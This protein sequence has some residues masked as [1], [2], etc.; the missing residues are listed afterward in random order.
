MHGSFSPDPD[1]LRTE[2]AEPD[3]LDVLLIGLNS[4][5][6][7]D[8]ASQLSTKCRSLL[9]ADLDDA[10]QVL[11]T[12][13]VRV[14]CLGDQTSPI[15]T[16]AFLIKLIG[17][18]TE[19][20]L[21][22]AKPI[23]HH[24]EIAALSS[25]AADSSAE[26][27]DAD[28][29]VSY[30]YER[31]RGNLTREAK[32]TSRVQDG[33]AAGVVSYVA[34][35]G[36]SVKCTDVGVNPRYESELDNDSEPEDERILAVPVPAPGEFGTLSTRTLAVLVVIRHAAANV[37]FDADQ[38]HLD[39]FAEHLRADFALATKE[40]CATSSGPMYRDQRNGD[41]SIFRAEAIKHH[42]Q[43]T[44]GD[45]HPLE[46][47]PRWA[48]L[49]FPLILLA[50][51]AGLVY[52]Q[53]GDVDEYT[54]SITID[55]VNPGVAV[56]DT[57][58]GAITDID[59]EP[60]DYVRKNQVLAH[61]DSDSERAALKRLQEEYEHA[62]ARRLC[63]PN[64][65]AARSTV[66]SLREKVPA[67]EARLDAR[68]TRSLRSARLEDHRVQ[69]GDQLTPGQVLATIRPDDRESG[70]DVRVIATLPANYRS[71][72]QPGM[73]LRLTLRSPKSPY[74]TL[75]V[76]RVRRDAIGPD[77]VRRALGIE[78]SN[79]VSLNGSIVPI[80]CEGPSYRFQVDDRRYG[81]RNGLLGTAE[82]LVKSERV[83]FLLLPAP[84][85]LAGLKHA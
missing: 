79:T 52:V 7:V 38:K 78:V 24:S 39:V 36:R 60:G 13:R 22:H 19:A 33:A 25:E 23:N 2:S 45:G 18:A 51:L 59:V 77:E 57:A 53:L 42:R 31:E 75:S 29:S 68:A 70:R 44:I 34:R 27:T 1:T 63:P 10:W 85:R 21:A 82:I 9:V 5:L 83:L 55:Y 8:F 73:D 72:L 61:L 74:Q 56:T 66:A 14:V 71:L 84:N 67:A 47:S 81:Y 49:V 40:A 43:G 32:A 6:G 64:G 58:G 46:L 26:L 11:E 17:S 62:L 20:R 69:E 48:R 35:A 41:S 80:Y 50:L 76:E 3:T 65:G 16:A 15:D 54:R 4:P 12:Y 37:F 28:Q 30:V